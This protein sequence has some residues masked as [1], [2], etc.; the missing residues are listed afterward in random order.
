MLRHT[1]TICHGYRFLVALSFAVRPSLHS[2]GVLLRRRF[3]FFII[4]F[5]KIFAFS[6][7]RRTRRPALHMPIPRQ[8]AARSIVVLS[9]SLLF[10]SSSSGGIHVVAVAIV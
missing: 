1:T 6:A 4:S 3:F 10:A 5:Q 9:S 2:A 8:T 7:S